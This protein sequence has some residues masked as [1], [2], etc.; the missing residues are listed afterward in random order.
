MLFSSFADIHDRRI[1]CNFLDLGDRVGLSPC[2][3]TRGASIG[4]VFRSGETLV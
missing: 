4:C 2:L 3:G 1:G